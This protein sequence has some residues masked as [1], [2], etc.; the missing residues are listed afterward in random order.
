[1]PVGPEHLI[2]TP[3]ESLHRQVH[4]AFVRDGRLSS[5]AFKPSSQDAGQLS[6]SQGS[7]ASAKAAFERYLARGRQ[8][9]GV[10]SVTV[11]ECRQA[12]VQAYEDA[13]TDDDAHA[14]IDF[15]A[16]PSKSQ[17]EKTS[18]KLAA[19]ARARGCQHAA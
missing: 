13:L 16:L 14:L 6:V 9:C 19:F 2:A 5:Q 11:D 3:T 1:M 15:A 7:L 8:S 4:P 12:G 10:W 18:D 17:W